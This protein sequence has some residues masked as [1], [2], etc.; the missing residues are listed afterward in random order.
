MRND[1]H[2]IHALNTHF[3]KA[4]MTIIIYMPGNRLE[5]GSITILRDQCNIDMHS[6]NSSV[7]RALD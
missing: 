7:G 6:R 2:Y 4:I 5:A 1:L 3:D